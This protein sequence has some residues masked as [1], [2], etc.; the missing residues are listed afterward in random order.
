MTSLTSHCPATFR[1]PAGSLRISEDRVLRTVRPEFAEDCL[2][3]LRSEIAQQWIA[4]GRLVETRVVREIAGEELELEHE[5]IFALAD[6]ISD[7][8]SIPSH[9]LTRQGKQRW[10]SAPITPGVYRCGETPPSGR[11]RMNAHRTASSTADRCSW[12]TFRNR[13]RESALSSPRT[14]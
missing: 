13:L 14:A 7:S 1:D 6:L 11:R 8:C 10:W 4:Q 9:R 12:C 2:N 5:P 3:F